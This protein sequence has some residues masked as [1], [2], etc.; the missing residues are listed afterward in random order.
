MAISDGM[1]DFVIMAAVILVFIWIVASMVGLN[2]GDA[3]VGMRATK[4]VQIDSE[5]RDQAERWLANHRKSSRDA[6]PKAL[7]FLWLKGDHDIPSIRLGRIIGLEA[8]QEG[9]LVYV[10]TGRL[11]WSKPYLLIRPLCSDAN[12]VNLWVHARGISTNGLYRWAIVPTDEIDLSPSDA[13]DQAHRLFD[14]LFN[15]QVLVDAKE[16]G[17]WATAT[18]IMPKEETRI[19]KAEATVPNLTERPFVPEEDAR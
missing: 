5:P 13:V 1:L 17:A 8:H 10:K 7:K 14:A 4:R 3:L 19:Q 6:K 16:D 12:R 11:A 9:Y 15:D 18:G 2:L